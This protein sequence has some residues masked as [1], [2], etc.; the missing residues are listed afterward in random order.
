MI[1]VLGSKDP[2]MVS[3]GKIN[4]RLQL[5]FRCYSHQYPHPYRMKPIPVQVLRRMACVAAAFNDQEL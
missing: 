1:A 4:W 5:Q 3:T 2:Q